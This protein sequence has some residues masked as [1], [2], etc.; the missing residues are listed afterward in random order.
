MT[1][2]PRRAFLGRTAALL[3]AVG[4]GG[5]AAAEDGSTAA[6]QDGTSQAAQGQPLT[7]SQLATLDYSTTQALLAGRV[8]FTGAHQAGVLT[9]RPAVATLAALD[10]FAPDRE[11]LGTALKVLSQ[12]AAQL[13]VGGPI[14][15][16][17]PD[18]PPADSGILGPDNAP[19]ELTVTIGLG[20]SLFD[21]RY[22]LGPRRPGELIQMPTFAID[23]LDPGQ[24]HGDVIVQICANE[25]DTVV[26]TLRELLRTVRGSLQLRWTI[27]GFRGA[28]R[29]PSPHSSPRNLF[30]FRDGTANP[31]TTDTA[32]MNQLIW[33]DADEPA[34][35]R[36]GTYMVV[37][38]IRQH[39]E[40][41]DRVGL[42]EQ[43]SMIGR[44]RA[45]GAP[46][47]G[48]FEFE[49]PDYASDPAGKRIPLDSHIRL[50]NPRTAVTADQRFLRRGFNYSRGEDAA[51]Q[52][53]EG[54]V[55]I[56]FNQSPSRQFATVQNRL[57]DE[58]MIDYITPVG[59]GYF[60]VPPAAASAQDWVG[61][62]LFASA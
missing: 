46:L 11:T 24:S 1:R 7:D 45:S 55:F 29:G 13:T 18:A 60:F 56:A 53:D 9:P 26:H 54:L 14:P 27:D 21:S 39:V 6:A 35:A 38:I 15:I 12:R 20:A 40:F 3:G 62:G 61:S 23:Q 57:I 49:D 4:A 50:A 59:G 51:G 25:R 47:G 32:L 41:W 2:V 31:D 36:G 52:L 58:P 48:T 10:S 5:L 33:V 8:P 16:L 42:T 28:S 22:G 43:Q 17:E 19:D 34:W 37:R 30:A 44:Y